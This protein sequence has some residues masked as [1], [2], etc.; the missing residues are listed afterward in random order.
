MWCSRQV[1]ITKRDTSLQPSTVLRNLSESFIV[2]PVTKYDVSTIFRV[3]SDTS[4]MS[5]DEFLLLSPALT[6]NFI[7]GCDSTAASSCLFWRFA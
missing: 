6:S 3:P 1:N 4:W 7:I 2:C 5:F